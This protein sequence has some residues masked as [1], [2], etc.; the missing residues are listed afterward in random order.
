P[1]RQFI[2]I[3]LDDSDGRGLSDNLGYRYFDLVLGTH[4]TNY[5]SQLIQNLIPWTFGLSNRIL[6]ET[7]Q[8]TLF[9]HRNREM[10]FN[11]RVN[12]NKIISNGHFKFDWGWLKAGEGII[13]FDYPL[14]Q[15]A[16][17]HFLPVLQTVL[18]IDSSVDN[19]DAPPQDSY[20]YLQWLQTDKRHYP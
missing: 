7:N 16:T 18:P 19:F 4:C 5:N 10:I 8:N 2:S 17:D 20:H 13:T 11:F 12:Q 6:R 9:T 15:I 1:Q 3:Y 14:R